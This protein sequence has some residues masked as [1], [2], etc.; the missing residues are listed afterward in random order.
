MK[1]PSPGAQLSKLRGAPANKESVQL[2]G[3][4]VAYLFVLVWY[5]GIP[6]FGYICMNLCIY[7]FII[8]VY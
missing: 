6:V 4:S 1:L 3:F 8:Y 2:L 5:I 7:M